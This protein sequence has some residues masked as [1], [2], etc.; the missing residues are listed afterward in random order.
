LPRV[1]RA[2]AEAYHGEPLILPGCAHYA[3]VAEPGWEARAAQVLAWLDAR[4]DGR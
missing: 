2:I 4:K 3:L 1:A